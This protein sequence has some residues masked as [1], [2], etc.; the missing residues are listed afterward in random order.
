MKLTQLLIY[1]LKGKL[2]VSLQNSLGYPT[3]DDLP[4]TSRVSSAIT[5]VSITPTD[6]K[7]I[8]E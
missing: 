7:A 4:N 2:V 3:R 5:R 6:Y 8:D 1:L